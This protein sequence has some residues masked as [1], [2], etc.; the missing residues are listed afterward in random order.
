MLGKSDIA[1][2]HGEFSGW[3]MR[4]KRE[5]SKRMLKKSIDGR[6]KKAKMEA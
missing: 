6:W 1:L 2:L 3:G 4:V 5:R